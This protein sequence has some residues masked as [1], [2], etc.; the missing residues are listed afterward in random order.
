LQ[1]GTKGPY[2][3]GLEALSPLVKALVVQLRTQL[4]KPHKENKTAKVYFNHIKNLADEMAAAGKPL[5]E[6][7]VI[8]YVL[9]GLNDEAYN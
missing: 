1:T 2:G 8:S 7:D 4:N 5:E 3:P 9:A 6:D